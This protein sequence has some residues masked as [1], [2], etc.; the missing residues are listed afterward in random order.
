MLGGVPADAVDAG[1]FETGDHRSRHIL[2]ICVFAVQ[3]GHTDVVLRDLGAVVIVRFTA[4]IMEIGGFVVFENAFDF[5]RQRTAV[6]AGKVVGDNVDDN[7][8]AVGVRFTAQRHQIVIG[9]EL[10]ADRKAGRLVQPVPLGA[11]VMR[12]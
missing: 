1:V 7:L 2:N 4:L 10:V 11:A 12:L 5:V 9:A 8:D 3:I 6:A